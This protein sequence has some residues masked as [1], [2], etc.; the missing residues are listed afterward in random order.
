MIVGDDNKIE[1]D[2]YVILALS[3][4]E[5]LYSKIDKIYSQKQA[6]Y[7][8][9]FKESS[10]YQDLCIITLPTKPQEYARK[11]AGILC[12]SNDNNRVDI[13]I[14]LIKKG[15]KI[16]WNYVKKNNPVKPSKLVN[17]LISYTGEENASENQINYMLM[18]AL[19]LTVN[20]YGNW[21]HEDTYN[22]ELQKELE[23]HLSNLAT[24]YVKYSDEALVEIETELQSLRTKYLPDGFKQGKMTYL[25]GHLVQKDY[26]AAGYE[27]NYLYDD[28]NHMLSK[29]GHMKYI[30][31]IGNILNAYLINNQTLVNSITVNRKDVDRIFAHYIYAKRNNINESEEKIFIIQ[32]LFMS[33]LAR[34]YNKTK[35][36]YL[37]TSQEELLSRLD[38]KEK[39]IE[40]REISLTKLEE[41]ITSENKQLKQQNEYIQNSYRKLEKK[42]ADLETKLQKNQINKQE[43]YGL[44]EQFFKQNQNQNIENNLQLDDVIKAIECHDLIFIG[45]HSSLHHKLRDHLPNCRFIEVEDLNL[46]FSF[47]DSYS[48][49]FVYTSY[50]SHSLYY[51]A[52]NALKRSDCE[53]CYLANLTNVELIVNEMYTFMK[54]KQIITP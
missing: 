47:I 31:T 33:A 21:D 13:I 43:L 10:Y 1:T 14:G 30:A 35:H 53:I 16:I 22:Q 9:Y 18:V 15:Y 32:S 52:M 40:K 4:N 39:E 42:I 26:S 3:V 27:K 17:K 44:R 46:D 45:G 29:Q 48:T 8:R 54:E 7:Y 34:E 37:E 51:K 41:E 50:L 12:Y 38:K 24:S 49:I 20:G 23:F 25:L 19:Y 6:V 28:V 11:I 2:I 36:M 5:K